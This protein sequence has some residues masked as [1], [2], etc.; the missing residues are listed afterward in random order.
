MENAF[1]LGLIPSLRRARFGLVKS[2][3]EFETKE[4][5]WELCCSSP[6]LSRLQL[7]NWILETNWLCLEMTGELQVP[8]NLGSRSLL[9]LIW[10]ELYSD[11]VWKWFFSF[12]KSLN[13][14][15]TASALRKML[16]LNQKSEILYFSKIWLTIKDCSLLSHISRNY[17]H[18][19]F[20]LLQMSQ[21]MAKI[22][23][24]TTTIF[25][26]KGTVVNCSQH[27]VLKDGSLHQF[28]ASFQPD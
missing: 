3:S 14:L 19:F 17:N 25:V 7:P 5:S 6:F 12:L 8:G 26:I 20:L 27:S 28:F 21:K 11:E 23:P 4:S 18:S 15:F 22:T 24:K 13:T 10:L 16:C 1:F 2:S 9:L